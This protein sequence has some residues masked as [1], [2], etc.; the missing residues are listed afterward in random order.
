MYANLHFQAIIATYQ[1]PQWSEC[2]ISAAAEIRQSKDKVHENNFKHI[3]GPF[4]GL[5]YLLIKL[6]LPI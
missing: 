4:T 3:T 1:R 5:V 6:L 2:L